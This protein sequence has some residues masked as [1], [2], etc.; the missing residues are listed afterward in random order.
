MK[1]LTMS[2][3][4]KK[5]EAPL[6]PKD[7]HHQNIGTGNYNRFA[8]LMPP[9]P[10]RQRLNSKRKYDDEGAAA[11]PK[12]PK[13]DP[14]AVFNQLKASEEAMTGIKESFKDALSIGE[15]CYV[16]TDGGPGE[17][18]FKLA[19]TVELLITNQES[20][21][22]LMVDTVG[23]AG[24]AQSASY[25]SVASRGNGKGG[26]P[27]S[28]HPANPPQPADNRPKKLR[29]AINKAER[30][31]TLF[32][33]DLGT[34]PVLNK[35]TLSRKVTILLHD[36]AATTGIYKGKPEAA[37][38]AMDDILSCASIDFLGK[39]TKMFFNRRDNND[40]RN[41]NMC[42]VPVKL[43][44]K[45]KEVRFQAEQTLKKACQVTCG[46]PYPKK[47]RGLIDS[48]VKECKA[49]RPNC[50]ILAK[51]DSEK[52]CITARARSDAGW[53]DLD[54]KVDIPVDLLDPVELAAAIEGDEVVDMITIS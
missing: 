20:M 14:N 13:L 6:S 23:A 34:V 16:A 36:K 47:L 28:D 17:A 1:A 8:P 54:N 21:F 41:G 18:F 49:L 33:L 2:E 5:G 15:N 11:A 31:V 42:T 30:S 43:T 52:L 22:T 53:E 50:F 40:E 44:F 46:T 10:G 48:L 9:P 29:Q 19:K 32:N 27:S 26:N 4:K 37:A 38:E 25:A 7:R 45:D 12:T 24:K 35:D 39:G 3:L 51:V